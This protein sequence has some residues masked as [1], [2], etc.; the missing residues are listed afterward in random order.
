MTRRW[1]LLLLCI[2]LVVA[3]PTAALADIGPKASVRIQFTGAGDREYYGTLLSQTSSTGPASAWDGTPRDAR[4]SPG[5]AEYHIWEAFVGYED[6]D[7][8]W[9]LQEWW[10][11]SQTQQLN[12]TYHP[13]SPFK[14]L[15][16]FPDDGSFAVS[17]IYERY[18]FDSYFTADLSGLSSGSFSA[19]PSY[20]YTWELIS[21][22]ARICLTILL[23]LAA[24]WLLGYREAPV[25]RLL[26]LAN[27]LTQI[28]LN[29]L[30]NIVNYTS[31]SLTFTLTYILL[32]PAV[33]LAEAILYAILIPRFSALPQRRGKA[34]LYALLANA[35]SFASGLWLAH[36]IPGIF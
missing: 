16:Y 10:D 28:G 22:A 35:V 13:P 3:W 27:I 19:V 7:G 11:C 30:L 8:F 17:P 6:E 23:E 33:F 14:I 12:W 34:V 25:L 31:G 1:F 2:T 18:A 5:D 15:L 36:I 9:F 26:A 24:A 20:D 21:L 29:V 4:S 32:E